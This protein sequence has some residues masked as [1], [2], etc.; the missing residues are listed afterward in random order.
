MPELTIHLTLT[1]CGVLLALGSS[2]I[3]DKVRPYHTSSTNSLA[4]ATSLSLLVSYM[5]G[6]LLQ[7]G[8][9]DH[10]GLG[11]GIVLLHVSLP[12]AAFLLAKADSKER[13][14]DEEKRL[15]LYEKLQDAQVED[16]KN[17]DV[18][19]QGYV[20][21]ANAGT[22]ALLRE[23]LLALQS[24]VEKAIGKGVAPRHP[25]HVVTSLDVLMSLAHEHNESVHK[26][27]KAFVLEM[28]AIEYKPGP[29]KKR[30]RVEEKT[31]S[32]YKG[33]F[34]LVVGESAGALD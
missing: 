11:L 16:R 15:K 20:N 31:K 23:S 25:P 12:L 1:V 34:R 33:D 18:S 3:Y 2:L 13:S 10:Y 17:Y 28:G 5:S 8:Y 32:D 7:L 14:Q 19:W 21:D 22:E 9:G 6:L 4:A 27:V 24:K 30:E 29:L 26:V